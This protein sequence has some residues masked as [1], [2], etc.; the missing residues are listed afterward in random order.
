MKCPNR[1]K[2]NASQK[3]LKMVRNNNSLNLKLYNCGCKRVK[4]RIRHPGFAH[5]TMQRKD[6]KIYQ[7]TNSLRLN[8]CAYSLI[9]PWWIRA[10]DQQV[11]SH[12]CKRNSLTF[13]LNFEHKSLASSRTRRGGGA[14]P[15]MGYI[16]MCRCEGYGFQ[17]VYSRIGY[18]NQ[19]VWV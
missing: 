3:Y 1:I 14:L 8:F 7:T 12:Q 13:Q 19:S 5:I 18:I 9:F 16:G 10:K 6:C 11:I 4:Q 17:A 2:H 15:Y